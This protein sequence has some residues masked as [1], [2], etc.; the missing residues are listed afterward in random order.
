MSRNV[1]V[2]HTQKDHLSFLELYTNT[3]RF[4][5]WW[6]GRGRSPCARQKSLNV[7]KVH[8]IFSLLAFCDVILCNFLCYVTFTFFNVY[9]L[10]TFRLVTQT[11]GDA[12]WSVTF[13]FWKFY[14]WCSL[15]CVQLRLV[16]LCHMTVTLCCITLCSN[17][18]RKDWRMCD[19]SG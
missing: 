17:I 9:V 10:E 19:S 11:F 5:G 6:M 16:T 12:I 15:R 2:S 13:K 14:V 7:R 8:N 4:C 18:R 3:Y 1:K